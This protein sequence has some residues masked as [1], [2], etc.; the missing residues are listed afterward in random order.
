MP[1]FTYEDCTNQSLRKFEWIRPKISE[2]EEK[3]ARFWDFANRTNSSIQDDLR[4]RDSELKTIEEWIKDLRKENHVM[5]ASV[6]CG[7]DKR[8]AQPLALDYIDS[9]STTMS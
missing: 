1:C 7:D 8:F 4:K 3:R 5:V 9:S 2:C 6:S